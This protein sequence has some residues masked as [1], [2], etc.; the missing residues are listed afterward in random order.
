M[1]AHHLI[2]LEGTDGCGK[3]TQA[4]LACQAL[5]RAGVDHKRL[6]FPR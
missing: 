3:S 4:E 5:T 6:I 1:K 2:V